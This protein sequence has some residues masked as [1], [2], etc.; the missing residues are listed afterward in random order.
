MILASLYGLSLLGG[1]FIRKKMKHELTEPFLT[2]DPF[3]FLEV[4]FA[5]S[6]AT[7]FYTCE[8]LCV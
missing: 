5:M 8:K 2:N 1:T 7:C 6:H 3:M 4:D